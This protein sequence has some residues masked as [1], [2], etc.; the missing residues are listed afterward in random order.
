MTKKRKPIRCCR[1]LTHFCLKSLFKS[2]SF[3]SP[4]NLNDCL[5]KRMKS[6]FLRGFLLS[7]RRHFG[8][9]S[10]SQQNRLLQGP[11][12]GIKAAHNDMSILPTFPFLCTVMISLGSRHRNYRNQ[13]HLKLKLAMEPPIAETEDISTPPRKY[14][15]LRNQLYINSNG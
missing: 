7:I 13:D 14:Y 5:S 10:S 12:S 6:E 9:A 2:F 8:I 1:L 11:N 4:T 3:Q 15:I